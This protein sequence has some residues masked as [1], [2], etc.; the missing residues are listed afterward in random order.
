MQRRFGASS[1]PFL[2]YLK[3]ILR[4]YPDGGQILKELIQNADDACATEVAFLYDERTFEAKTLWNED[5]KK[6]Q[7]P[8]LYAYNNAVFSS[9]DWGGIQSTGR[10]IKRKDPNKVGRFGIGFNSVYHIT[11]LPSIFSGKHLG[12]L[13]PQEKLFG[14]R[15]GGYMWS[16][17]DAEDRDQLMNFHDQFL[18][19]RS[20][21]GEV[22]I[23]TWEEAITAKQDFPGTLFRFPLRNEPSAVSDKLYDTDKIVKLFD[24]FSVDADMS[25][26]FLRNVSSISLKHIDSQGNVSLLLR[27][28]ATHP[29]VDLTSSKLLSSENDSHFLSKTEGATCLKV[30]SVHCSSKGEE[31]HRWLVTSSCIKK[32]QVPEL[33]VFAEKLS[34]YPQVGLAFPLDQEETL[35][36]GRL[37]CFLPLPNNEPNRTGFPVHVNACFGLT[38]NRRNIKWLEEDQRHD[39]AAKWNELL[40][41]EFLPL[42]YLQ[43]ILDAISLSRN[44]VLPASTP[45]QLWPDLHQ[46]KH[47]ERWQTIATKMF[48]QLLKLEVLFLA[49]ETKCVKPADAIFLPPDIEGP[50]LRETIKDFLITE[51]EFLAEVPPH[52]FNAIQATFESPESLQVVTPGFVRKV[53]HQSSLT[54]LTKDDKLFLLEYVISDGRYHELKGLQLLPLS[55][56]SF[57]FFEEDALALIE[58]EK[59]PRVLLPGLDHVFVQRDLSTNLLHHLKKLADNA[60][61]GLEDLDEDDEEYYIIHEEIPRVTAEWLRV[62][63]LSTRI[64]NP[65]FIGIEQCG[66]TEPI[67]LRIKNILKE[68]DEEC[69][70]FKELIQNAED[71]RATTCSFMMDCRPN[72][73]SFNSLIDPGMSSCHGPCLW[74]FNNEVFTDEDFKNITK[75]GAASKENKVEKIGKFGLGFNAVYRVTD[76]PT[77]LSGKNLLIFDPNVTHLKKHI[78]SSSNPGI[79][80][81][82]CKERLLRRFPGQFK[83]Y[84]GIYGCNLEMDS[85]QKFYFQGTLIKLPFR[86]LPEAQESKI[87]STVYDQHHVLNLMNRFIKSSPIILLFLKN[88]SNVSFKNLP[89][90]A[91]SPPHN[92][93]LESVLTIT[94]KVV[95]SIPI[96]DHIPIKQM[97]ES[98]QER[99]TKINAKCRELIDCN[100]VNIIE[101]AKGMK[102]NEPSAKYWLVYSC[103]GMKNALKMA[104]VKE[105]WQTFSLPV[106]SVAIPLEKDQ[107]SGHWVPDKHTFVGQVF[108]FLP[109]SILS[110]LPVHVN[111]SFSVTS[112]R[113]SLWDTGVKNE[114]NQAL[115]GD[116]VT[117][118]YIAALVVLKEMSQEEK[119]KNYDYHTFWPNTREAN[120]FFH[121]LVA[122]FYSTVVN[123]LFGFP[124]ELFSDGK[125]WCSLENA[126]F[127]DPQI[128]RNKQVGQIAVKVFSD[129]L[130]KPCLAIPLP[131]WVRESLESTGWD[132]VIREKTFGWHDFYRE[133]VFVNLLSMDS[134]YRNTL[135]LFAID[136]NDPE[137]DALLKKHPCIPTLGGKQLQFIEKL[138]KPG[139][140]VACLFEKT[141]GRLLEGT[142]QDF[143]SPQH[144]SRLLALGML[145][146]CLPWNDLIERAKIIENTWKQD[147]DKAYKQVRCILD[148]AKDFLNDTS[149]GFFTGWPSLGNI[150]FIPSLL[151]YR[152][153]HGKVVEPVTLKKP[154][155][156]YNYES[157]MLVNMTQHII[158]QEKLYPKYF[159]PPGN[160]LNNL[161]VLHRPSCKTVIH[162]LKTTQQFSDVLDGSLLSEIAS[163]CYKYLDSLLK[164]GTNSKHFS[165]EPSKFPFILI[166]QDFVNVNAVA[167]QISIDAS[168]YLHELPK[169]YATLKNLW[170]CVGVK[171]AFTSQDYL[172]VLRKLAAKYNGCSLSASDLAVC[173]RI[174]STGLNEIQDSPFEDY[175]L[176]DQNGVLYPSTQ[177]FYNDTP[178]LPVAEGITLCHDHISRSTAVCL[179]IQTTKH[180]TLQNQLVS[181]FPFYPMAFGQREKLTV[182]LKNIIAAYPSKKDILKELLQNADDAEATEIHFVWDPRNHNTLKTFGEKWNPLQGPALCVYNNKIFTETD[183]EGIQH[184][185]EGGKSDILGKTG[186][187]GLGFNSVYHLTDCPSILTGDKWLCIFDPHLT[188]LEKADNSPGGMF[189][190]ERVPFLSTRILNPEFIGIEQC[191]QTEP[192]TL[193]IKNILKEYDEE[194]DLFKELIQNAEDARA[195]TCSF[196]MDCRPNKD[197]F[198]SLIDPGMSS[199]HGPCLWS[200]NNEVFTDEDFKNITKVGAASKENKV[201]KIGKF[202]LGFNAV[203]RVT[204]IPTILSGKNL[205]I[206]DPNVTHLKKHILSSSNPGIKLD[207]CKERLLRRFPGQ[208][209][210]YHGIYGCNLEMDSQQKF[211]FQGTLIKLPFRTLPEAQ[212]SKI[213][214]TV[215]DQNHVLNLMNRFI[216]SSPIIL[217]FLKNLSNVSFKNLPENA[218]SPPHNEHL[219]SVLTITRKVVNSIP[220]PDH[221]PI[222]QMQESSQER[223]T[224]INAKCRELIDC[225]AVNIIEV[226]KG[227]KGN[228]PSAKYWLVYSC[229]GM[230]N[231]LKMACVK[232]NWQ[233]FSLPVGSV[234]IPL[235]KDQASGHWVPDKHTFVGQ[236]FCFLPLSILSGLPV[237][238]NGSFSVTS[239]RK[240][241]WDTGV[242]NEW[243]Q[244]LIGDAVTSAYIAAL[245]VLKEMSQEEKLKNYD[246]HTFW[247]NTREA[248]RFFHSLVA[249]FYS[250]VVNG[251]FGFPVELFSD[252]KDWCSL[253]NAR[254]LDPQIERNKQVGQIAVKVFSDKLK[255]PCLAIPLPQWVRESLESTG[256]DGVIREKTF[257]WHDFYREIV[258]VNLRSMDSKYRNTLILF[259]IDMNDPEVDALL[260]KH[261]C[262]PTLGGKQL[263]FIG[264]LVKP[265]GKVACLF[266]KTEGRL[267]EGTAQDF[268]SPQHI[269]R[270]LALGM[271]DSCLPWNDLIERAK[272]IENTW[273]QDKDKAYKQVCCI[274]DLAKDFLNDTPGRFF[275]GWPSL[276]NI[277]F[278]PSLL[279][280]RDVHGKVVEPVTLKKPN[281]VYNYESMM[282][283]NMTQHIIDQEKLYPKYFYPPGNVLNNLGVLHRP[284]CKT[285]IHQLK[286]TQQFSDVL[287]GSLLSEIASV[288]YKYL[289]S[290]LK[291]GTNSKHFSVEPS[292]FPFILIG[293]DFVNVN[294]VA[295]QISIDASPY[296]HELPKPY[297]TLKNLWKC[298]G[299]KSVFT[300]QDY[301]SVLRKLAAKYNGCSLSAS[302]LAV[303]LRIVSTGLNEIQDS[304]FEDYL[305]PDQNG[306]LYPS[307]QLFYNDTPWLPVAEG[308]TLCHDHISRSTAVC[309]RIQTT[310]HHTLQNQLVS[311]FPFYPMAFGQREKLT[312]RLKNI[313]AAYPS[314][315]DILKELLQ[316]ADDA[317]AT[318]IHFVWDPRNH[319]TLKTFGEKWNP[320]QG[321]ALCVY[322]NKI[323]TETDLEGIQHLG[324]GGK[325]DIL[326]KT[327]KYGLGFNSV[328]HLTDCPSIL[329]GDKWLCIFDPHLTYLE[330]A[331]NSPGGMF[332]ME[333]DFKAAFEDIYTTFMPSAFDLNQ[334]TMFRLPVRTEEMASTSEI[335]Q[336]AVTSSDIQ[337]LLDALKEDPEGLILFLRH[338][339]KIEFHLFDSSTNELKKL[340]TTEIKLA[341]ESSGKKTSFQ[342]HV[343]NSLVSGRS[344]AAIEPCQVIYEMEISTPIRKPTRW[345][346][347][348]QFGTSLK[349]TGYDSK[350][351][352][353]AV[354]AC[355]SALVQNSKAFCSLPLPVETGLP[356][357]V[358]GNFEVDPSRRGLWK[359]DGTS[360]KTA[361]NEFLKLNVIA[362]L[363]ADLLDYIR[364][365]HLK[366]QALSLNS[367]ILNLENSYLR[368]FPHITELQVAQEW[369]GMINEL[370]KSLNKRGLCVIPVFH[371][372]Q[373]CPT[374]TMAQCTVSWSSISK[375]EQ[376]NAPHLASQRQE[377]LL[378]ILE[379]IGM[380]LVPTSE[381]MIK[382]FDSFRR[383]EVKVYTLIPQTVRNYL[384]SKPLNDP[385]Q[386]ING[387]P[388]P[389]NQTLIK[390]KFRC[391]MLL[392]YC[393]SDIEKNNSSCLN[394]L[395]LLLTQDKV[396]RVFETSSSKYLT[397]FMDLFEGSEELFADYSTYLRYFPV[398]CNAM[399]L[400][401]LTISDSAEY[402]K[403]KLEDLLQNTIVDPQ[404]SLHIPSEILSTWLKRLW[405]Y[406]EDQVASCDKKS[407]KESSQ[408]DEIKVLFSDSPVVPIICPNSNNQHLL[409]TVKSLHTIVCQ[410]SHEVAAVLYKLGFA[411]LDV[412]SFPLQLFRCHLMPELLSIDNADAV[413][414][415]LCKREKQ[416]FDQLDDC[417]FRSLQLYLHSGIKSC[418]NTKTYL[419]KFKS[420]P[421]FETVQEG[422][423]R[424]DRHS[425][426]YILKIEQ[427]LKFPS[428]Y[429]ICDGTAFLKYNSTNVFLAETMEITVI[430]DLE[431]YVRFVLPALNRLS[432]KQT[433][434]AVCMCV[435]IQEGYS[436][437]IQ[438]KD[439]II[440]C[441]RN[442][443]FIK[444]ARG[445]LQPASYFCDEEVHLYQ[446]M[447]SKERFIPRGFWENISCKSQKFKDLLKD[448]G[449]KHRVSDEEFV[450]FAYQIEKDAKGR[451]PL[452]QLMVKS[453]ALLERLLSKSLKQLKKCFLNIISTIKFVYPQKIDKMLCSYHQPFAEGRN[454]I[455]MRGSL[456]KQNQT[457]E[458]LI[459]TAMPMLPLENSNT[460]QLQVL[461]AAGALC[462]PPAESV[463][464]NLKNICQIPCKTKEVLLTRAKVFH[465]SYGYLQELPF[466]G[467]SLV[468]LPVILVEGDAALVKP[469]R[470]VQFVKDD[471]EFRPYLYKLPSK[472]ALYVEFFRKLGVA[473]EPSAWHYSSL[474][475][476]IYQDSA[477]MQTLHANQMKAVKRAVQHLFLLL[478]ENS[479]ERKP[480]KLEPLYLLAMDGRLYES[481]SLYFNDVALHAN[482]C[483]VPLKEKLTLLE[484][485]SE[486]HLG[487]DPYVH[488]ELLQVLPVEVRPKMLSQV[489][490]ED[491]MESTLSICEYGDNC[492][493]RGHFHRLL[494]SSYFQNGLVCILRGQ[495]SGKMSENDTITVCKNTFAKIQILCCERLE[496]VLFLNSEPLTDTAA[497]KQVYVNRNSD[498]CVFYLEHKE[499]MDI[500][501]MAHI[502][503]CLTK[504]INA[505]LNNGLSQ[506]SLLIF[507]Q[508]LFCETEDDVM[509]LLEE[510][511]IHGSRMQEKSHSGLPEPGS[512]IPDE[513]IDS[514]DMDFL[515]NFE[516]GEYVGY[517]EPS[518]EEEVYCYAV[519]VEHVNTTAATEGVVSQRYKIQIGQNDFLEVSSLD[520]Y[521]FKRPESSPSLS[522]NTCRELVV[523]DHP[524]GA[525]PNHSRTSAKSLEEIKKEIDERL[526]EIWGLPEDERRKA[527]RR[528]YLKWHP[529]KNLDNTKLAEEV[530]KYIQQKIVELEQGRSGKG[531]GF[532]STT[533][534]QRHSGTQRYQDTRSFFKQW[535]REASRHR[536]GRTSF[537]Q[538]YSSQEFNFWTF[539]STQEN[540][541]TN[542]AEAQRW[543][544][545]AK[546]DLAAASNDKGHS[547][548]EWVLF[549]VHQAVE[550][551]LIAAEYKTNG[552]QPSNCAIGALA[553]QVSQYSLSLCNLPSIVS[554]MKTLGVDGKKTQ[555]PN[556][557][558][559]PLIPS[560]SYSAQNEQE[561]LDLANEV[562]TKI[563]KY[564]S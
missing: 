61:E 74:S 426:V 161:G 396:L 522:K 203:Y 536:T 256:W 381:S 6:F 390:S 557:H 316:N 191:G 177:L 449:L 160:V 317:E 466:D 443:K 87:S 515:N 535:D 152:D 312:V 303:C 424:I 373:H 16:L 69:D 335:S 434:D 202:G 201:E 404:S 73:D 266:E 508:L 242:K 366:E 234:A 19:F 102:G 299:V 23:V 262:I 422:R 248:N 438:F 139:G 288:C 480:E 460:Q 220:I 311:T 245:V 384:K 132:S 457:H 281:E 156:V 362:P 359:E 119:L 507:S 452:E 274:L 11:D 249:A 358:N 280:Y 387:L 550:K 545:Q 84:H 352:Q 34:F 65:E 117:S 468:D 130:K 411:T 469:S 126:R 144:I 207:L 419:M 264:K 514:L 112:N 135:I 461:Q 4:R 104:C 413:L 12:M 98:S 154:N 493:F 500:K 375:K 489:T 120:R 239:N 398:L 483:T 429:H 232:E 46:M 329:T 528:L 134:K 52:V 405:E 209:K 561:V 541:Q 168:P 115:I 172:S 420:L 208:F 49:D 28:T 228:E 111:G 272:I 18:P 509:R 181:T 277:A 166:G 296:L 328:Y 45:Y 319:N 44:S 530:Y 21:L 90:N 450:E 485:L 149:S 184:L 158:D 538:R 492:R 257:G 498:G 35:V 186:K 212:E 199:C 338:V 147:K 360:L 137:V 287:D 517:K 7:G 246:Y 537:H 51:G 68:Y 198:N 465:C 554:R 435:E 448:I 255:K 237:H 108:C 442:A 304:P 133:I 179:R 533:T 357:Q 93:H 159:Y 529:D 110:G 22:S 278:I 140:K 292:K 294:A 431:F 162:Q 418:A 116:A 192:I 197:S 464:A 268:C 109:L 433:L 219:E 332:S 72:K 92:E 473:E 8:A 71:A 141:E 320:L 267:L 415:Q 54:N 385:S 194:C 551:A 31:S 496:T 334:G 512:L 525:R 238:V 89:E 400:K 322:N 128:E 263:Q 361:W 226:A 81:D 107:A 472:L 516:V 340:F 56:G 157:M 77:I 195:T 295:K 216:K 534:N 347:A 368:F 169:P 389:L 341:E 454:F 380:N 122:A 423:Q 518:P 388:L 407:K 127:L 370:Y 230:K 519:V 38:D 206:F 482:R 337:Q 547:A 106:G 29:I 463:T 430:N 470:T 386:S 270:L 315:K 351:P 32:G 490:K 301:L 189:S 563:Q 129:K 521:Q 297:A 391:K 553:R 114:W 392:D 218:S 475:K 164:K 477:D 543:V 173:L 146:S 520:L 344:M 401:E 506:N 50:R 501:V 298:V 80:L 153:V 467:Q 196:M 558:P 476:D 103:F 314:K 306:V 562:L 269:S 265:G 233:T 2:D 324:E 214:S 215:Y 474:L 502:N 86:T 25:L 171:S 471:S 560:D 406:F 408:L 382:I 225:N 60:K 412:L 213:S 503:M 416:Q 487:I 504:E 409:A 364:I 326:G 47:K 402:L 183:L 55:D 425:R 447:I 414:E 94:R 479:E 123:G 231:A 302:D 254:F 376:M 552:L 346:I 37:S 235:E 253:E 342:N 459:W 436:D 289:D 250:T 53:L 559:L 174:V 331:D 327:G 200:F 17:D 310:K 393:L 564:I 456:I 437:Y 9:E 101:V 330:K 446:L 356:V 271:L 481:S 15:E 539:H 78:L 432:E 205:L 26:L 323:F 532:G 300:S 556:Y 1:P 221:I 188:Y 397:K 76:I 544:R 395:P 83:P 325:S 308:I 82:L 372:S 36:D 378:L 343:K 163:V 240:S 261:P 282:L 67:T 241:L 136:M 113:K 365:N 349:T 14:E 204:D 523:L 548:T 42:A 217:L 105:N 64:L 394:G 444:D 187:Y 125:D 345:I 79:K 439:E 243:N 542:T 41:Q 252:G 30:V 286:T 494:A 121:S 165:V 428:L 185:G 499:D 273:K 458:T 462:L 85:Q 374:Q 151:P 399:F 353:G 524:V 495:C 167:K 62:P 57:T 293:Q 440:S 170:K 5:L 150:A 355:V 70:L 142:A 211:Y 305:L 371:T 488:Q 377:G 176:P 43:I 546:C 336:K 531:G 97:Q 279:P 143:C 484:N 223:L 59:F 222:K 91:S 354:A 10:S 193:R 513:W 307:T 259:A 369:H 350:V 527:I 251:L 244:A 497:Q 75:V 453:D 227:M 260:K 39:E 451:A 148:L 275:I 526:K 363:Y 96:P 88:L 486:C 339:K 95:N 510:N 549:K 224:K 309:L 99:L 427:L 48:E 511:G 290:L 455:A 403:S 258:F 13:D 540:S 367:M 131:Q 313:I 441:L 182:R 383:A 283:V 333:R 124:V 33:D 491:L 175:L 284:S 118:A 3:D 247:P 20:L 190:M 285:V 478:K 445:S 291:K 24:S 348:E 100:A 155:E 229:F 58:N 321:P 276:G 40:V 66:Q 138:V 180:H 410:T 210:P 145:D 318:E 63:F 178:W 417:D 236:V 421:L 27:V 555:Y 505:L 379:G